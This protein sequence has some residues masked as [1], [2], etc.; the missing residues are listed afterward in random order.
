MRS[1]HVFVLAVAVITGGFAVAT[2]RADPNGCCGNIQ[3]GDC[4]LDAQLWTSCST[5]SAGNTRCKN[6][7]P[8]FPTCCE[9]PVSCGGGEG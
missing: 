2:L 8:N 6:I 9:Y 3:N 5:G 4:V 1:F 7:N